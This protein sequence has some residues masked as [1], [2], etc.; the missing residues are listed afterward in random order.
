MKIGLVVY[1]GFSDIDFFLPWDLLNRVRLLKLEEDWTVEVL[2]DS[3]LRS[4]AGLP[5]QTTQP[6]SYAS[7]CD[8][9]FFCSGGQIQKLI[10]NHD[11]L[12]RFR[13]DPKRQ[14][15]A[16][17]DSGT[18]ILGALGLLRGR[19]ATTYPTHFDAIAGFGAIVEKGALVEDGAIATAARCLA[20]DQLTLWMIRS[21][22]GA[23][24]A[25]RVYDSV[26]P[27]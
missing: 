19:R 26:M 21:L 17:I 22:S 14:K 3:V 5:V 11:F 15:I 16:A 1:E 7:Q 10:S 12:S 2:G 20:G 25:A 6:Y 18:L 23:Q 13:L 24:T 8:G 4:A 27:L 9:V